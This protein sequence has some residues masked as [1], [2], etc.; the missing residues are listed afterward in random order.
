MINMLD[1]Y[2]VSLV[3]CLSLCLSEYIFIYIYFYK[4]NNK[5]VTLGL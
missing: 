5:P 4:K 3:L 1:T 2:Y